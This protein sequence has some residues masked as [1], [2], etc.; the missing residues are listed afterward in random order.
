MVGVPLAYG[1]LDSRQC[2]GV[3]LGGRMIDPTTWYGQRREISHALNCFMVKGVHLL[4][5]CRD[6][7][8]GTGWCQ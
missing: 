7:R 8:C 5:A 2:L 1:Y 6:L 4:I 3:I